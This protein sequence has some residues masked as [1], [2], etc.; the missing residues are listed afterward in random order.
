MALNNT[1]FESRGRDV[2]V[3]IPDT[4]GYQPPIVPTPPAPDPGSVP[5]LPRPTFSGSVTINLY[6]NQSDPD[7][8][9]KS[10][11]SQGSKTVLI[12]EETDILHFRI[13]FNDTSID[14]INYA[15][16]MGRYYYVHSILDNAGI[17]WLQ[18]DV[19]ALMSWKNQIQNLYGIAERTGNK[20][21]TYLPDNQM[22]ITAYTNVHT[23]EANGTG[24]SQNLKYYLLTIGGSPVVPT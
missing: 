13:P 23:V 16:M 12:R 10:I 22:K 14:D 8:L 21:N 17:T 15:E 4:P 5:Y 24:F 18:F 11:S 1:Y 6:N 19:D 2:S 3:P 20:Y 9:S 7:T